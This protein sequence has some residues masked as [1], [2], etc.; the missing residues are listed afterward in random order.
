MKAAFCPICDQK[1]NTRHFCSNCKSIVI[2]PVIMEDYSYKG[3]AETDNKRS[4]VNN[5]KSSFPSP[6]ISKNIIGAVIIL[7]CTIFALMIPFVSS[8]DSDLSYDEVTEGYFDDNQHYKADYTEEELVLSKEVV[9]D[10]YDECNGLTHMNFKTDEIIRLIDTYMEEKMPIVSIDE[11]DKIQLL[12]RTYDNGESE[13]T[14]YFHSF[15]DTYYFDGDETYLDYYIDYDT[16]SHMMHMFDID[17]NDKKMMVGIIQLLLDNTGEELLSKDEKI[18]DFFVE[19]DED[20]QTNLYRGKYWLYFSTYEF[21]EEFG[22]Y[23]S[24]EIY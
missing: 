23:F 18:E 24:I 8:I 9:I 17:S 13:D 5:G 16:S 21:E 19:G 3:P 2:S 14:T 7:I 11:Y 12:R 22:Y 20:S 1:M 6:N 4:V 10:D 15:V